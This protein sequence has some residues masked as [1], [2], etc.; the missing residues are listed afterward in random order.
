M[1]KEIH[2]QRVIGTWFEDREAYQYDII[3]EDTSE[4]RDAIQAQQKKSR[5]N[6]KE[7]EKNEDKKKRQSDF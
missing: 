3:V 1:L 7:A 2:T 4:I 5:Q 6:A